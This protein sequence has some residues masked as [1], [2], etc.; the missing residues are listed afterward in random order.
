MSG[1]AGAGAAALGAARSGVM[2]TDFSSTGFEAQAAT[3][4]SAAIH[5]S[6]LIASRPSKVRASSTS[7]GS[8]APPGGYGKCS[9]TF[10]HS[11][12]RR[13]HS[14]RRASKV[15]RPSSAPG[16]TTGYE[17]RRSRRGLGDEVQEADDGIG[18]GETERL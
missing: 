8:V 17:R 13:N 5:D 4:A 6:N 18:G 14:A 12:H 9:R 10:P 16:V 2:G 1:L 11:P 15:A 7:Y 3:R